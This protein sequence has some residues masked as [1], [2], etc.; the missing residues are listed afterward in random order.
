[1][2]IVLSMFLIIFIIPSD[3]RDGERIA[4]AREQ[5][6]SAIKA[7]Q[8]FQLSREKRDFTPFPNHAFIL[9]QSFSSVEI[10]FVCLPIKALVS[11]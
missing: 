11:L 7:E 4:G 8:Q 1:M 5:L 2:F 6:F 3:E 10:L 9:L